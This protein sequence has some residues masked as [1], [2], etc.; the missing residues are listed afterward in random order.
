[1]LMDLM[2]ARSRIYSRLRGRL[3]VARVCSITRSNLTA[4]GMAQPGERLKRNAA[5]DGGDTPRGVDSVDKALLLAHG[6]RSMSSEHQRPMCA[7]L[8]LVD[9]FAR[10][11]A[12]RTKTSES[13]ERARTNP[14]D[15][16]QHNYFEEASASNARVFSTVYN[17][18][19]ALRRNRNRPLQLAVIEDQ[20]AGHSV[21]RMPHC[22]AFSKRRY[23]HGGSDPTQVDPTLSRS[24][25]RSARLSRVVGI[26]SMF[27]TRQSYSFGCST[28]IARLI[29]TRDP[30]GQNS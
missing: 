22:S 10:F 21:E 2:W 12:A 14:F 18:K 15:E 23:P 7:R 19:S 29:P 3:G 6:P 9:L 24:I 11:V 25:R 1:M 30:N 8:D 4:C 5:V 16:I 27:F 13:F 20:N 28:C 17:C 26:F